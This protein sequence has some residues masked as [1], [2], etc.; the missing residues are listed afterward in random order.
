MDPKTKLA[1]AR[2]VATRAAPYFSSGMLSM[3]PHE[4]TQI[5]TMGITQ[6]GVLLWHREFVQELSVQELAGVIVHELMHLLQNHGP[7]RERIMGD[8]KIWNIAADCEI[9]DDL[10]EMVQLPKDGTKFAGV[11]PETFGFDP[12]LLA[13]EYYEK[14]R[15]MAEQEAHAFAALLEESG[16]PQ[17]GSGSGNPF[18]NESGMGEG[19]DEGKSQGEDEGKGQGKNESEGQAPAQGQQIGRSQSELETMRCEV[20]Q[21]VQQAAARARGS[22]PAGLVRWAKNTLE[23]PKVDWRTKLARA[24]RSAMAY[25]PGAVNFRYDRPSRRQYS[26]GLGRVGMPVLPALR[27]PTPHVGI[28]IDTSGSMGDQELEAA[29]RESN[30]ILQAVGAVVDFIAC[31]AA[32]HVTRKVRTVEELMDSLQGGGGT[33]FHPVFEAVNRLQPKPEVFI[34]ITDGC[35]PAP[36]LPPPGVQ[37]VWLLVGPYRQVP[38]FGSWGD[39]SADAWGEFIEIDDPAAEGNGY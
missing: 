30:G 16:E 39:A 27:Q 6:A 7:R 36:E 37:V 38:H 12:G 1:T 2:L 29:L 26:F 22:M 3:V 28:G 20:A 33:D 14:L 8:H 35:G 32:V 21:A 18:P 17:C 24:V 23:P 11:Y 19:K 31:D 5:K 25:R 10:R 15:D 34:F 13:E 4:M 9:N